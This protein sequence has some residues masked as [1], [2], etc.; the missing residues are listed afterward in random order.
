M[1]NRN[2]VV[3][4]LPFFCLFAISGFSGLIYESIWTH[5]IKLFLGH[6]AYAQTLVLAIFMGGMAAGAWFAGRRAQ[7]WRNPLLTYAI[8]EGVIGLA[9]I[10]FHRIFVAA[11]DASYEHV[12]PAL[13][14]PATAQIWKWTLSALL[15]LPQS[16]L[17]GM[18][19]PLMS[20]GVL[21]QWPETPGRS[22]AL[23]YFT[24]SIGGAIGVLV[25]GFYLIATLGLPGTIMTAGL[26]N[27]LL[28]LIVGLLT[29]GQPMMQ[30]IAEPAN[31]Q[32]ASPS[33]MRWMLIAS[34]ITGA[35]SFVYEIAWIR[36]LSLV[37][38]SSTH[39][40]ELML[41]AFILGL[42]LGGY[43]IKR[44]IESLVHPIRTLG[45]IQI[46]MAL[47]ALGTLP[48]YSAS[49]DFMF[50]TLTALARND[51]AYQGFN[52]VSHF[53]CLVVMLPATFCAGMTLPLI[54]FLLI[55]RGY[56]ERSIGAVYSANTV[57]GIGGVLIAVNVLMP[58]VGTKGL[59]GIGG[60][61][62]LG[63]GIALLHHA[64][65]GRRVHFAAIAGTGGLAFAVIFVV[66]QLNVLKLASGVYRGNGA[67]WPKTSEVLHYRD[68]KT[69]TVTLIKDRDGGVTL[70]T[71]GKPD[72]RI[73]LG[74]GE[75]TTDEPT[76]VLIGALSLAAHPRAKVAANIGMGSG[77]TA[78]TLLSTPQLERLDTIEIEPEMVTAARLYGERVHNTFDDPRSHIHIEDAK[79][80]FSTQN[81][82]YDLIASEPSN[83][84]VSGV[85]SLFTQEFYGHIKRHLADDGVFVQ[86]VQLYE[87][88]MDVVA[89]VMKAVSS[90]FSDYAVIT[91]TDFDI[92]ILARKNGEFGSLSTE[93]LSQPGLA[94]NLQRIGV[95]KPQ[96]VQMRWVGSK[97]MLDPMFQSFGAPEN[98]D[99]F[100]FVDQN[101]VRT[102]FLG[103][104]GL[105]LTALAVNWLP[106]L[107]ML[108]PGPV[109]RGPLSTSVSLQRPKADSAAR[110]LRAA[111]LERRYGDTMESAAPAMLLPH[112]FIEA[113]DTA[114]RDD[115]WIEGLIR[116]AALI[117]PESTPEELEP[118]WDRIREAKCYA[119]RPASM[120]QWL[121]LVRAVSRRDAAAMVTISEK[122]LYDAKAFKPSERMRYALRAAML[123]KLLGDERGDVRQLWDAY[124]LSAFSKPEPTLD[125]RL[126]LTLDDPEAHK[127][128]R[129]LSASH[130]P[131]LAVK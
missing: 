97:R 58:M 96:D 74:P 33:W 131:V 71:N 120:K 19:F 8:V 24:N 78:H 47:L 44:R 7:R 128:W 67:E 25:S 66:A 98:S 52:L 9:A 12:L 35:A 30:A 91:L 16:I 29:R 53:I 88:D 99:Y 84:W 27:L 4:P 90:Q 109:E 22:I 117:V 108:S 69:A 17:L 122:L 116:L 42:A 129:S 79:V 64:L 61:L 57:G 15:I 45:Y 2:I 46:A 115:L 13:G 105:E 85:S 113:C 63:L 106:M 21:R 114:A 125:V 50:T 36:L 54:T 83:P 28:A 107:E 23:L 119:R 49:F 26:I 31:S 126:L 37:L 59:L 20:G 55:K 41:S 82:K 51:A 94:K 92:L 3:G 100:P 86:W 124:G 110:S 5:Y 70:S 11:T 95:Q 93:F 76:M 10:V 111:I 56:G 34:A 6:A 1:M 104:N 75:A 60:L 103:V 72:A 40:F 43:W 102:R 18:T 62:D 130:V 14:S 81:R 32:A 77:L 80:F 73:N 39:A 65:K 118:V 112:L 127:A 123:G 101:A 89:S 38:G 48:F 121:D 87:V 68:G